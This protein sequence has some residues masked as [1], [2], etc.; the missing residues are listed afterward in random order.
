MDKDILAR[1]R[2]L[3]KKAADLSGTIDDDL[4][5]FLHKED[6]VTFRRRPSS[7]SEENDTGVTT[8][9]S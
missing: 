4:K 5:S 6:H 9:Y 2:K 7:K 8:T 3:R 1:M